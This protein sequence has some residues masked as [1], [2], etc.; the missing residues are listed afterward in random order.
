MLNKETKTRAEKMAQNF[1]P[2]FKEAARLADKWAKTRKE[3]KQA[4]EVARFW[5]YVGTASEGQYCDTVSEAEKEEARATKTRDRKEWNDKLYI[6]YKEESD[7]ENNERAARANYINYLYYMCEIMGEA[8]RPF[9]CEI[10]KQRGDTFRQFAEIINTAQTLTEY[11]ARK[12]NYYIYLDCVFSD[13]IC[14][15][16]C[17][18]GG[19]ACGA[20][21]H[22]YQYYKTE[23]PSEPQPVEKPQPMTGKQWAQRL[24]VLEAYEEKARNLQR[25]QWKKAR[26]WGMLDACE[27]LD[28]PRTT[29]AR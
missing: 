25:E 16:I 1:A 19:G 3:W 5:Q 18:N 21:S 23:S 26:A 8:L 6:K 2:L 29:K 22:I 10:Y 4:E 20:C 7:S 11:T 28:S 15:K 17:A 12:V 9:A 24:A 14:L 13:S 27:L